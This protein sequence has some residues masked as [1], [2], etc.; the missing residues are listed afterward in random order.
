M[1]SSHKTVIEMTPEEI[2]LEIK[3]LESERDRLK[4]ELELLANTKYIGS[5]SSQYV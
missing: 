5:C 4:T 3:R 2:E 1:G